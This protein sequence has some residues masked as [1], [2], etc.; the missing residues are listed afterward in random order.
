MNPLVVETQSGKVRGC[1]MNGLRVFR[2][3]PY[4]QPPTGALRFRAPTPVRPWSGVRD[5]AAFGPYSL[6]PLAYGSSPPAEGMSEDCLRLNVYTPAVDDVRRPVLVWIHGGAFDHGAG[7]Q[8]DPTKLVAHGDT[9]VVTFNY[10]VGALGFLYLGGLLGDEYVCSGNNGL[11]DMELVL[12]WVRE[13]IAAFG[14]DP[15]QV[16]VMGESAGAKAVGTLLAVPSA[17]G[18]FQ[19]AILES[20]TGQAARDSTTATADAEKLLRQLDLTTRNAHPLLTMPADQILDAQ[21][22]QTAGVI[23]GTYGPVVDGAVLPRLP[24][25]SIRRGVAADVPTIIGANRDEARFYA[26]NDP[27]IAQPDKTRLTAYFGANSDAVWAGYQQAAEQMRPN[28]AWI[29]T[30]TDYTYAAAAQYHADNQ[31]DHGSAV[32][33]Y[34]FDYAGGPLGACHMAEI[35]L[36]WQNTPDYVRHAVPTLSAAN[37]QLSTLMQTAWLNFVRTLNPNGDGVVSWPHYTSSAR[38]TMLFDLSSRVEELQPI[39]TEP[40]FNI[41]QVYT[42]NRSLQRLRGSPRQ[43]HATR[44]L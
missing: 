15:H 2:G 4:A 10:R 1:D 38:Q 21:I 19:G 6:Q 29:S 9:V 30:L 22:R 42:S 35:P 27:Q 28:D 43:R 13:N 12:R 17:S 26:A 33:R 25:E 18:L 24:L 40:E 14:G 32:W 34:R 20:G 31:A 8:Y 11:L 7:S 5:A 3:I 23:A 41:Q 37:H 39:P 16:V 36:I 44:S